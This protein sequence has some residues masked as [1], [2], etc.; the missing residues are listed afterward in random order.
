[1]NVGTGQTVYEQIISLDCDN[2]P[3]TGATFDTAMYQNGNVYTGITVSVALTDSA[4]GV[5]TTSW[6]ASTVGDYQMY[7][8]NNN[9]SVVFISN[10]VYVKS[11]RDL[12]TNVYIGL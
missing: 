11:D 8:K 5:F 4:I 3:V 2:N 7:A 10:D 12:D 9:T 1:M 6:S